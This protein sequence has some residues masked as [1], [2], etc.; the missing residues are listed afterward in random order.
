MKSL[1]SLVQEV[2]TDVG[3][4]CSVST[5]LD[6]K[7]I[8]K[9]FEDEGM[10]FLTITLPDFASDLQKGLEQG[11]VDSQLFRGFKRGRG[12]LPLF[13][14]GFLGLVFDQKSGLLLDNPSVDAIFAIRQ[15]CLLCGKVNLPC[16]PKRVR[17]AIAGFVECEQQIRLSDAEL[18]PSLKEEFCYVSQQLWA[19]VLT[20]VDRKVYEGHIRPKHG[21]GST[22]DKLFGNE[23]YTQTEWPRRL[24][25]YFPEGEFLFPN[26][27]HYDANRSVLLEP[28][29]ER[30]VKVTP[31]PK[32]LKTPRI[33]AIE[34]TAM[35]YVQQGLMREIVDEITHHDTMGL[36]V[37]FTDQVPNQEL[38]RIASYNAS[39]AT[40]DL[41]EASDR[42]SNQHVRLLLA[43]HPHLRN[44]VDACRSRKAEVPGHGVL[45]LAKFASMGS[46][47]TFPMEA[48]IFTTI[49]FM[50]IGTVLN[51]RLTK[52]DIKSFLGQVRVYGDDIIVPVE[53]ATAVVSMLRTFGYV[54]NTGKSFWNGKFR[55]SCGKEYYD[56]VDVSVVR[57]RQLLP[58]QRMDVQEIIST[59]SLRNQLYERGL[60]RT[61]SKLDSLLGRLIPFPAVGPESPILGRHSYLGYDQDEMCVNLHVPLVK[62]MVVHSDIPPSPLSGVDALMKCLLKDSDMPFADQKHLER[63]GRP[64]VVRIKQRLAVAV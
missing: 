50:G 19:D 38:A 31:V 49:I 45:R 16:T 46:A 55:E 40:L 36:I 64:S 41:S 54:V 4:W 43:N 47:L 22:A 57:V 1:T 14:G 9:R 39:L 6:S 33:I 34:P 44:G 21:P 5:A 11:H 18:T 12:G 35:Q 7:T 63:S 62:G 59:V 3:T 27:R 32:T 20:A 13:L 53:Y 29:D 56:G 28:G 48:M 61:A 60:W 17:K 58:T 8:E 24:E 25:E 30:P 52:S 37:G 26:W 23:K 2:L 42:V 15:I 10:S 51:R